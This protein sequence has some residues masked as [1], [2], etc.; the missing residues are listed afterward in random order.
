MDKR[1]KK[2]DYQIIDGQRL[3]WNI[4]RMCRGVVAE[5]N[6]CRNDRKNKLS[7]NTIRKVLSRHAAVLTLYE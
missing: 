5:G 2:M 1:F 7:L 4:G 6:S 3:M